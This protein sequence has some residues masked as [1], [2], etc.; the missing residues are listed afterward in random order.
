MQAGV[1]LSK[2]SIWLVRQRFGVIFE[3]KHC[4]LSYFESK[5][6]GRVLPSGSYPLE[7]L[8]VAY[9]KSLQLIV[10]ISA[11]GGAFGAEIVFS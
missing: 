10:V 3:R 4:N 7:D 9:K 6:Y 8:K 11:V 2:K 1:F 5:R